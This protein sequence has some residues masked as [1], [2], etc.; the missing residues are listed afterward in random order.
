WISWTLRA[1][2]MGLLRLL[3][4]VLGGV[5]FASRVP[6]FLDARLLAAAGR[7]ELLELE[8]VRH[9]ADRDELE[10]LRLSLVLR[11]PRRLRVDDEERVVR[12]LAL[13]LVAHDR[14]HL[15]VACGLGVRLGKP[16]PT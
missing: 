16:D 5:F 12:T 13:V 1:R 4:R 9:V 3:R 6:H 8:V 15:V 2:G 10:V 11:E 7:A 14:Q